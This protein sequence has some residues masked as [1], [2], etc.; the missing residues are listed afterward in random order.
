MKCECQM[1]KT[2]INFLVS[3]LEKFSAV[4]SIEGG[5][6][7]IQYE[8]LIRAMKRAE[9]KMDTVFAAFKNQVLFLKHNLNARATASL[10]N[11]LTT[12]ESD[13]AMLV[14]EMEASIR[15][16]DTF[17]SAMMTEN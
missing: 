16:A 1:P 5:D 15:E 13:V 10:Q 3:A 8:Q 11:A 7:N 2:G 6:L 9:K 4:V 14:G 17:I 12:I